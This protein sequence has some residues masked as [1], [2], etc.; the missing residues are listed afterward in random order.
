MQRLQPGRRHPR[1]LSQDPALAP[2]VV[3]SFLDARTDLVVPAQTL[4]G[5]AAF[6]G[7]LWMKKRYGRERT[8]REFLA[9]ADLPTTA[10]AVPVTR[11][12]RTAARTRS[13]RSRVC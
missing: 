1:H 7:Y 13:M 10:V 9:S 4:F 8:M 5:P 2:L 6:L 11:R 12:F 3:D